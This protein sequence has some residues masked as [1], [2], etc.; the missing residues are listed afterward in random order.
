ME[1]VFKR[2]NLA[3]QFKQILSICVLHQRLG[4]PSQ[5]GLINIPHA[6]SYFL[7]TGDLETLSFFDRLHEGACLQQ[8]FM[9]TGIEPGKSPA[10]QFHLKFA[11][12]QVGVDDI[13]Y[14]QL[15]GGDWKR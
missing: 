4:Q 8:G 2:L 10:Q 15:L 3:Q 7:N 1:V 13:R 6:V 5:H 14:L 11:H 9:C 12:F